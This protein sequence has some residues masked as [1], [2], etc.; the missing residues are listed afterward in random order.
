MF[1]GLNHSHWIFLQVKHLMQE[2]ATRKQTTHNRLG[3]DSSN[4]ITCLSKSSCKS[5]IFMII[6]P[7]VIVQIREKTWNLLCNNYLF[8]ILIISIWNY[9]QTLLR[10]FGFDLINLEV[11]RYLEKTVFH[12][13]CLLP[14]YL[15]T[16]I[17]WN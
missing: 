12:K 17:H 4:N 1:F 16:V 15:V 7:L 2:K 14:F 5:T 11:S 3:G 6:Y 10:R 8:N 9:F 13:F